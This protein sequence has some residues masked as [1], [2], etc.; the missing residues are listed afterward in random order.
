MVDFENQKK[1]KKSIENM[2]NMGNTLMLEMCIS[3]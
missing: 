2:L 3:T 1:E